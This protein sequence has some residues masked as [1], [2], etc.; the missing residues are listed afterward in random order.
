[1]F[2]PL[3]AALGLPAWLA[4]RLLL[5][6]RRTRHR[7]GKR[8]LAR[9]YAF[10]TWLMCTT[11]VLAVEFQ[12]R[13]A[14]GRGG[15]FIVANHPTLIDFVLLASVLPNA[16][17]LVKASLLLHPAM[18]WAVMLGGYIPNDRGRE[19]LDLCQ[20]SLKEGNSLV[21]FPEGTRSLPGEALRFQRGAAQLALRSAGELT[22]LVIDSTPSNLDKH[23]RW[24]LAPP[25]KVRMRIRHLG[26][27]HLG[28]RLAEHGGEAALAARDL[29]AELQRRYNEERERGNFGE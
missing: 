13:D 2:I 21:V 19:T 28:Q 9:W 3:G 26:R 24:W 1:M 15:R 14:W 11:G 12:D 6:R 27:W 18:R 7:V 5:W 17:G 23:G 22:L 29:T 25:C 8:L 16:D 10:F 4:L 20:A